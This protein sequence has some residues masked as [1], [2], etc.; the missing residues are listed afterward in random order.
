MR[1]G[2]S[3]IDL[4]ITIYETTTDASILKA[5]RLH[6]FFE[7][8][9]AQTV[10][11]IELY[12]VT[13]PTDKTLVAESEGQPT[14]RFSL[15][16]GATNLEFQDGVLGGR[17]VEL[18]G[19]FGDT[20]AVRPGSGVYE[21]LFAYLMPYNKKLDLKLSMPMPV[22][23]VVLLVPEGDI[24]VKSDALQDGGTN[25]V[26]GTQYRSYSGGSLAYGQDL[27]LTIT[28][29][30]TSGTPGL[31]QTSSTG[32]IVGL[33]A[34]GVALVLAGVWLY[35]RTRQPDEFDDEDDQLPA[36]SPPSVLESVDTVTDAI[37][38]LDDLYQAGQLPEEAYR[39]RRAELK[40]HLKVLMNQ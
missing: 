32:L 17:Y 36:S 26:Q 18:P 16:E 11:V 19:G 29:R 30:P 28:G 38:A 4:P 33:S 14:V 8:V 5:D 27:N 21:A 10:R 9:D 13:N 34:F 25:D 35:R 15:P 23:A 3:E 12:I 24:E 7:F 40:A 31:A 20:V 1:A 22:D 39:Q 37:L 6:L 2:V